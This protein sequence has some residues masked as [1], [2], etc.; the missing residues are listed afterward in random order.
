MCAAAFAR[1]AACRLLREPPRRRDRR[2]RAPPRR[3]ADLRAR[4]ARAPSRRERRGRRV[5]RAAERREIDVGDLPH[6]GRHA[7]PRRGLLETH[8]LDARTAR[9]SAFVDHHGGPRSQAACGARRAR[10]ASDH[11]RPRA[12]HL[13]GAARRRSTRRGRSLAKRVAVQ[14]YGAENPELLAGLADRGADVLRVPDLSLGAAGRPRAVAPGDP[15]PR[16]R[17]RRRRAVHQRHA[18]RAPLSSRRGE[19][20]RRARGAR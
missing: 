12:E 7:N 16:S 5:R 14:E 2:A 17:R 11:R 3:R 13:A 4:D 8:G 19:G 18:G 1:R 20:R 15:S 9:R 10:R 6:R